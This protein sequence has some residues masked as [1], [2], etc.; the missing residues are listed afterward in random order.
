M[1]DFIS[2]AAAIQM[3]KEKPDMTP[4]EKAGVVARLQAIPAAVLPAVYCRDCVYW[5]KQEESLQ[6]L[7]D[8]LGIYPT[9][10]WYCANGER[11]E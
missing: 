6:G 3:V 5:T 11:E 2:R 1:D 10:A 7:C 8:L 4:D 9:G